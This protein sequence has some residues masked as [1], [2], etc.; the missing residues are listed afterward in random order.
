MAGGKT[1]AF[2]FL[3]TA[4]S[5]LYTV[6]MDFK[7]YQRKANRT[8]KFPGTELDALLYCTLGVAG[9]VGEL[10]N[11]I[12]KIIRDD[13]RIITKEKIS[14]I[15]Y[16]AGDVLWYISQISRLAGSDIETVAK[17]NIKK[18]EER[19]KKGTIH[20]AGDHR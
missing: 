15:Q 19:A 3:F 11:K 10:V 4:H 20:G 2:F 7:E 8:G 9:E 16:E 17:M 1:P 14:E 5:Y 18:L 12:K 6:Y 13:N